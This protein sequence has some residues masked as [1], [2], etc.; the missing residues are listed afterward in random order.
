MKDH[1][2]QDQISRCILGQASAEEQ[3]HSWICAACN[4]EV[5]RFTV[6]VSA[7]QGV[8]RDWSESETIPWLGE[9]PR[10]LPW[11]RLAV[12]SVALALAAVFAIL[13]RAAQPPVAQPE[14]ETNRDELL[15]R[16]VAVQ[17]ARPLPMSM[18]RVM[19]LL[20]EIEQAE[21]PEREETR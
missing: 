12:A 3:T 16:E 13:F 18:E 19:L 15:M 6:T 17:L 11:A 1:L 14:P 21:L 4:E 8:M 5:R 2:S 10:P 7:F 9:A 20:P